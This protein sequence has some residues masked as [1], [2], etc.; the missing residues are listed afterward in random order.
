V[1][2]FCCAQDLVLSA[3]ICVDTERSAKEYSGKERCSRTVALRGVVLSSIAGT[4]A[5]G[6]PGRRTAL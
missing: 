2:L 6:E 4:S 3:G 5:N 1:G